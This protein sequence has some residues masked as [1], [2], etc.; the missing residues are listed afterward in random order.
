M[1]KKLM[2]T[3]ALAASLCAFAVAPARAEE[4]HGGAGFHTG[5][6]GG[7]HGGGAAIHAGKTGSF[8]GGA[9]AF[10]G[11]VGAFQGRAGAF[12]SGTPAFN[13]RVATPNAGVSAFHAVSPFGGTV[14]AFNGGIH[15]GVRAPFR[16]AWVGG[17][18][19]HRYAWRW[20]D[21]PYYG[22]CYWR[23]EWIWNGYR[24]V[25]ELVRVC[26]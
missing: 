23:H 17:L 15:P 18:H 6:G 22:P 21:E 16:G 1:F 9:G 5:G 12:P 24:E 8:H 4:F 2:M 7:F 14:H 19:H 26:T 10:H 13:A 25:R 20:D 3:G 11:G